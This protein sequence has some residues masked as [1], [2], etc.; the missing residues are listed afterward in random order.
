MQWYGD[1]EIK[2]KN[3][4]QSSIIKKLYQN[5]YKSKYEFS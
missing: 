3:D 1:K 2:I 5:L 4:K